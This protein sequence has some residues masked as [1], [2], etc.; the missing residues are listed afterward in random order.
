MW[1]VHATLLQLINDNLTHIWLKLA[2][3]PKTQNDKLIKWMKWIYNE[4]GLN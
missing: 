3:N 4:I 2:D 1:I